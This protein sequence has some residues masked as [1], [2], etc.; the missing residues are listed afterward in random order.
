[1]RSHASSRV[2]EGH[3][4]RERSPRPARSRAKRAGG[5]AEKTNAG[6][7]VV[8]GAM[9][10]GWGP[11][12]ASPVGAGVAEPPAKYSAQERIRTSTVLKPPDPES[13]ASTS[14]ATWAGAKGAT[15]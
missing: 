14:S 1:M 4:V 10:P 2:V 13:G 3:P 9:L 15:S 11:D 7:L 8:A 12:P 6:D 5:R